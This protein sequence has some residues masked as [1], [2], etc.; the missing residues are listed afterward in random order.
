M[1]VPLPAC[2]GA[3][4]RRSRAPAMLWLRPA[5]DACWEATR[6]GYGRGV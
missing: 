2:I 6:Q 5:T 3:A 4:L 1:R